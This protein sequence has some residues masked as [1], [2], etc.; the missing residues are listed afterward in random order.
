MLIL[1]Y[2]IELLA[3]WSFYWKYSKKSYLNCNMDAIA[4]KQIWET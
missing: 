4:T 3:K 2:I 1:N